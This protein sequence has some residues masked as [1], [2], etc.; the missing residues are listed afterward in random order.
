L[1][2]KPNALPA[3]Q[4]HAVL[5]KPVHHSATNSQVVQQR[6]TSGFCPRQNRVHNGASCTANHHPAIRRRRQVYRTT[7][8]E[9]IPFAERMPTKPAMRGEQCDKMVR[10]MPAM[11]AP[12]SIQKRNKKQAMRRCSKGEERRNRVAPEAGAKRRQA[13]VRV[14]PEMSMLR[15]HAATVQ[16]RSGGA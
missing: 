11:S 6:Y 5:F 10:G 13:A 8:A 12:K 14:F 9:K 3:T 1:K 15:R 2:R 16:G 7:Y 4:P